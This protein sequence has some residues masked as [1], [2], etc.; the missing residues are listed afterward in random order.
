MKRLGLIILTLVL[1]MV[2]S[3][4]TATNVSS[5]S[6][7]I[8]LYP[9]RGFSTVTVSGTEF[10]GGEVSIY[11]DG[12]QVPTVPVVVYPEYDVRKVTVFTAIISVLTQDEPGEHTIEARDE[13]G[14]RASAE[15]IVID[16]TGPQGLKGDRGPEGDTGSAGPAGEQGPAGE[17]GPTGEPG[18]P[19]P[20]GE[21]GPG[22]GMSIIAVIL[23]LAAIVLA[24]FGRLKKW[25]VGS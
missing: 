12:T 17:P 19:G 6:A 3:V 9:Q 21:T 23:A 5:Q 16:M 11:W 25:I 7:S 14:G 10:Y 24:I 22:A 1:A 8:D 18:E 20:Q 2:F 4:I 13:E 15:F